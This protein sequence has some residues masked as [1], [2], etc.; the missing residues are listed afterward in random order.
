[1][2]ASLGYKFDREL[3]KLYKQIFGGGDRT[4]NRPGQGVSSGILFGLVVVIL[5]ILLGW[6]LF[7]MYSSPPTVTIR[8]TST[9]SCVRWDLISSS[10]IGDYLCVYGT[11][12]EMDSN[13]YYATIIRFSQAPSKLIF[14]DAK[15]N[16]PDLSSGDCVMVKGT[17]MQLESNLAI[18]INGDLYECP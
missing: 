12:K 9:P 17:I 5:L 6:F 18:D 16:Y 11:V 7:G 15:Y 4:F 8:A 13:A 10:D 14:V 1:M 3:N 2:G